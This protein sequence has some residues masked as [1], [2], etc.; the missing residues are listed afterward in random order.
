MVGEGKNN[1]R[2][3]GGKQ[4]NNSPITGREQVAETSEKIGA[5]AK[6]L[7]A[8]GEQCI[9][10]IE[11]NKRRFMRRSQDVLASGFVAGKGGA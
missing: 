7:C 1:R 5:A 2:I 8:L 11:L 10:L 9:Y 4:G 6:S 3:T